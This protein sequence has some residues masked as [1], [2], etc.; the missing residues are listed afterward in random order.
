MSFHSNRVRRSNSLS[1]DSLSSF[2]EPPLLP[3]E[4]VGAPSPPRPASAHGTIA[5][6]P[7][8][9]VERL[10][11]LVE[12]GPVPFSPSTYRDKV[13]PKLRAARE[14]KAELDQAEQR[15]ASAIGRDRLEQEKDVESLR[16][17]MK[18]E[19]LALRR[20]FDSVGSSLTPAW[21]NVRR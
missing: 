12:E 20:A 15:L 7:L 10:I 21:P 1:G 11:R 18:T 5:E 16:R 6:T 3:H 17:R 4:R 2:E 9:L 13:E 14:M 19:F 8:E